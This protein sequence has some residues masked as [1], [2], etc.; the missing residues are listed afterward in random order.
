MTPAVPSTPERLLE[1]L[2]AEADF[3]D[4]LLG[5]LAEEYAIRLAY[6][7]PAAA[8][9]WYRGEALR[10]APHLLRDGLRR[11]HRRDVRRFARV[12]LISHV[13]AYFAHLALAGTMIQA[14][15]L[16][17]GR[18]VDD[19]LFRSW[20]VQLSWD[21]PLRGGAAIA[22]LLTFTALAP[23]LSGFVAA[24]TEDEAPFFPALALGVMQLG[25]L[26]VEMALGLPGPTGL[27]WIPGPTVP[28]WV[29]VCQ[30]MLILAGPV[31]GAALRV[32][33]RRRPAV[34]AA[35]APE[36]VE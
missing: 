35:E 8:R 22:L 26:F 30:C 10:V 33:D 11:L 28:A 27:A 31:V 17:G 18:R 9:R 16:V 29:L 15:H 5:D 3:R 32:A 12:V 2:G 36:A 21:D 13:V 7:G 14:V 6:D 34:A 23:V 24:S 20:T 4:A 19:P 25:F 1:G